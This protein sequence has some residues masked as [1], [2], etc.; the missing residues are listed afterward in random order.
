[1]NLPVLWVE[2]LRV[3]VPVVPALSGVHA[4]ASLELAVQLSE[5]GE[6][7]AVPWAIGGLDS[8]EGRDLLN[9]WLR[10]HP[11]HEAVPNFGWSLVLFYEHAGDSEA[12]RAAAGELDAACASGSTWT[13]IHGT[14]DFFCEGWAHR[15][16]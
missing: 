6:N 15:G 1:M 8:P 10:E 7:L 4:E 13:R 11:T 3:V 9:T 16:G 14:E 5:A 2:V 12:A